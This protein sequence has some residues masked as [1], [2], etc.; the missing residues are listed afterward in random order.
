M[1]AYLLG[2]TKYMVAYLL[3]NYISLVLCAHSFS[4]LTREI[5]YS[6]LE[7]NFVFP[8]TQIYSI[9]LLEKK[10]CQE[11]IIVLT[12]PTRIPLDSAFKCNV[13]SVIGMLRRI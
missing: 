10:T 11:I 9:N 7:I 4:A 12:N 3:E 1:V 6:T 2:N 5:S 13:S 8:R